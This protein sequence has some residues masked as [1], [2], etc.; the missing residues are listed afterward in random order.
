MLGEIVKYVLVYGA[1]LLVLGMFAP[2]LLARGTDEACEDDH[3]AKA[4]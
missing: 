1:M 4:S 2:A 3:E